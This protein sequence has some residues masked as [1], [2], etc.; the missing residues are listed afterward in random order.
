VPARLRAVHVRELDPL[1]DA[2]RAARPLP[3]AVAVRSDA[4]HHPLPS[5]ARTYADSH[6]KPMA[7]SI[8]QRSINSP[9]DGQGVRDGATTVT[10][11]GAWAALCLGSARTA[12]AA[13]P[14]ARGG[15]RRA[16]GKR[17]G[18]VTISPRRARCAGTAAPTPHVRTADSERRGRGPR[19][20]LDHDAD[21]DLDN[22]A[23]EDDLRAV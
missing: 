14:G 11:L 10:Y 3:T 1:R 12:P 9:A 23:D 6:C 13:G 5:D 19:D 15:S 20:D 7:D 16:S 2:R 18:W 22:H 8:C 4:I 17:V 21:E